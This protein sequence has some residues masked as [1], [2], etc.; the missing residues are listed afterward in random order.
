[1]HFISYGLTEHLRCN[2][3]IFS[4][5]IKTL[6]LN[7]IC[8]ESLIT[9]RIHS[10]FMFVFCYFIQYRTVAFVAVYSEI[11]VLNDKTSSFVI[12]CRKFKLNS[13]C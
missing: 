7:V 11:P 10:L 8:G 9:R 3:I 6:K 5:K 1:M 13:N 4:L 12:Q 2:R